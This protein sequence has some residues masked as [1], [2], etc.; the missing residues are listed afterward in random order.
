MGQAPIEPTEMTPRSSRILA[1]PEEL[2]LVLYHLLVVTAYVVTFWIWLH[3]EVSGLD[4]AGLEGLLRKAVFV[5]VAAPLLGWVS[6]IDVGLGYHNHT[7]QPI[8]KAKWLNTWYERL[9]TP[10]CA[11]PAR[12]W[13]FYHCDVHHDRMM[14]E[15]EW[16]DWTVR[17]R[18]P[19]GEYESCLRYQLRVWPW[20]SFKHFPREIRAGHFSRRTA[21]VEMFWFLVVYSIPFIIDPVM[22]L[23][24][25]LLPHWCGN[26]ITMGRGMYVQHAG[27][28]GWL[29]DKSLPHSVNFPARFYN[30]TMF[31]I[32]FHT[33]HHDF[34]SLHWTELPA[35]SEKV[36][37]AA[38]A[39]EAEAAPA[40]ETQ[41]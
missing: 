2:H 32:G 13:A 24:L 39:R 23:C 25:W 15:G 37:T 31:N 33:E 10:F 16:P 17:L 38:A 12:Y 5:L 1:R 26:A 7:H 41:A 35:F 14:Q 27:R 28:E 36:Q 22:G 30:L 6:G 29:Q 19:N 8:F 34:P 40:A 21:A 18:K 11:W 9:W 20:R 4:G 3:P